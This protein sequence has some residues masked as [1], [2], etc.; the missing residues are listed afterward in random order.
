MKAPHSMGEICGWKRRGLESFLGLRQLFL[1][2]QVLAWNPKS[3]RYLSC[4][5]GLPGHSEG[6]PSMSEV[7][8]CFSNKLLELSVQMLRAGLT[9]GTSPPGHFSIMIPIY[10]LNLRS[11]SSPTMQ[12]KLPGP[13]AAG[14]LEDLSI[15][16]VH[17]SANL[18]HTTESCQRHQRCS[19]EQHIALR[20]LAI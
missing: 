15:P 7:R 16:S 1:C 11:P 8:T 12:S 9:M 14:F 13:T 3:P 2:Y 17:H 4:K 20:K 6:I 19:C 18:S 10:L 5:S